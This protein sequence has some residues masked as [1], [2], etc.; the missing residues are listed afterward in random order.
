MSKTQ[1]GYCVFSVGKIYGGNYW[2]ILTGFMQMSC[3]SSNIKSRVVRLTWF[4]LTGKAMKL[5]V[6]NPC[7][8]YK[9]FSV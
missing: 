4:Y 8:P 7:S 3:L 2:H 6:K 9:V 5:P 1:A